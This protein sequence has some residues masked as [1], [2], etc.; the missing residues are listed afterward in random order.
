NPL[1]VKPI[2]KNFYPTT[3]FDTNL[4]S[5]KNAKATTHFF[6]A[7]LST[8]IVSCICKK[9]NTK[10]IAENDKTYNSLQ[11]SSFS[12]QTTLTN[13]TNP[14][15]SSPSLHIHTCPKCWH[16]ISCKM[17]NSQQYPQADVIKEGEDYYHSSCIAN[18]S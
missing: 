3:C 4:H 7:Q 9:Y 2:Q 12:T 8:A 16:V 13:P 11:D 17:V 14:S 10:F 15:S 6:S 18:T 5:I 1:I